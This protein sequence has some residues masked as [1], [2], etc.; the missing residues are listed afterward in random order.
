MTNSTKTIKVSNTTI[1]FFEHHSEE[2]T[3]YQAVIKGI[4]DVSLTVL[5]TIGSEEIDGQEEWTPD[6]ID[7][8]EV[9]RVSISRRGGLVNEVMHED[10]NPA[11]WEK[12]QKVLEDR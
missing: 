2:C 5:Y 4:S 12:I 6:S 11:L 1:N 7:I 10:A 8:C 9:R 3:L